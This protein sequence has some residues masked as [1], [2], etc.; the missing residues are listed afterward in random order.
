MAGHN[1]WSKIKHKKAA[2][3]AK[4]SKIFSKLARFIAVESRR[5]G[6]DRDAPGLRLAIEKAKKENMPADNIDRAVAKGTTDS[7]AELETVTYEAYGPGGTAIII[8]GLTDNKNRTSQE[9]KHLLNE[10]GATLAEPGS[11][12]WAFTKGSDALMPTT[13]V[14][15]ETDD[16]AAVE[17]LIAALEEHDDVQGVSTNAASI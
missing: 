2:S 16:Q 9:I 1:K 8:E 11:A 15:L 4:K 13:T 10:H 17:R 12:S 14:P 6:G 7:G 5:A 3:D